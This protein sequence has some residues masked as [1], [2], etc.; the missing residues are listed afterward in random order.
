MKN[1]VAFVVGAVVALTI[2]LGAVAFA[3]PPMQGPIYPLPTAFIQNLMRPCVYQPGA[4]TLIA[5]TGTGVAAE[6]ASLHQWSSYIIQ[7]PQNSYWRTGTTAAQATP[8]TG[9]LALPASAWYRVPT[10]DSMTFIGCLPQAT[11]AG[12]VIQECL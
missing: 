6:S 10:T 5:C 8:T 11:Q 9:D 1:L 12:C 3:I 4:A 2:T 7:C